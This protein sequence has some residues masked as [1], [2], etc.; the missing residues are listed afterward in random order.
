MVQGWQDF[1]GAR[2]Y[3]PGAQLQLPRRVPLRI[4]P[5]SFFANERTYL[6]WIS[7]AILLGGVSTF[8]VGFSEDEEDDSGVGSISKNTSDLIT[9][10]YIPLSVC[11]V[12][13]SF[14]TFIMRQ[15]YMEKKE[16]GFYYD[17]TGPVI[18]AVM[19]MITL[20]V[21]TIVAML[22]YFS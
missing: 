4:E 22:D 15:R 1:F 5:K 16:M 7:M 14:F 21:I 8:L 2:R 12:G 9:L 10:F 18:L 6:S 11:M 20:I 13:Y 3:T 17:T 19:I